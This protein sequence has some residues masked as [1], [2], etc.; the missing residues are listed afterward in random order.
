MKLID[1]KLN[2]KSNFKGFQLVV[3][4]LR[5][6]RKFSFSRCPQA[7]FQVNKSARVSS[8]R[9]IQKQSTNIIRYI[10]SCK[11]RKRKQ[12]LKYSRD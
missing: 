4:T 8:I 9:K 5:R 10:Y 7:D 11:L 12:K 2:T 1:I 3:R 6:G